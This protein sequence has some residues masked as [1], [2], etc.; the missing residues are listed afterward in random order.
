MSRRYPQRSAGALTAAGILVVSATLLALNGCARGNVSA[1]EIER[2]GEEAERLLVRTVPVEQSDFSEYGRYFGEVR[3]IAQATLVATAG[4]TVQRLNVRPGDQVRRG[5]SLARIDADRLTAA[6]E[7]AVLA[8]RL[9]EE[10]YQR[11]RNFKDQGITSQQRVDQTHLEWLRSRSA[12]IDAETA[13]TGAL[14]I[15]PLDGIVTARHIE[16]YSEL[17]PGTPTFSVAD[18]SRMKVR[19][20]VP[21]SDISGVHQLGS[22]EVRVASF[23]EHVWQGEIASVARR[24]SERGLTF[25]V[26]VEID[27]SDGLLLDGQ[28]A[29]VELELRT[30]PDVVQVPTRAIV[31]R[32]TQALVYVVGNGTV[33]R[34]PVELGPSDG[35]RTVIT[36]GLQAGELLVVEGMNRL[37]DG[38]AVRVIDDDAPGGGPDRRD[39][40]RDSSDDA[41]ADGTDS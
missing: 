28:T 21:E 5:Q 31:N 25:E 7:T 17:A 23:P 4:G 15:S 36:K 37:T 39:A 38:A 11:E 26:E 12:R 18:L 3:S 6:W 14:A 22:A 34:R 33:L 19:V 32:G 2:S 1:S 41:P 30:W 35:S 40:T 10:A 29:Q 27:N 16:L 20:G 24:R 9:A 8:E 13:R